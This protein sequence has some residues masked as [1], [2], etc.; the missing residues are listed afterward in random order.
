M[1]KCHNINRF[2][3]NS[4][5]SDVWG[6]N[7]HSQGKHGSHTHWAAPSLGL[8]G[9]ICIGHMLDIEN[10]LVP[11]ILINGQ[12]QSFLPQRNHWT[13][14]FMDSYYRSTPAGEY[15]T[16][17]LLALRETKCFTEDDVFVAHLTLTNDSHEPMEI[18]LS[19]A[20]PFPQIT[21]AVYQVESKISPRSIGKNLTLKGFLVADF[22]CECAKN[23]TLPAQSSIHLRYGFAFS[24]FSV[25]AAK[26]ALDTALAIPDPIS[27][28]EK[29]FNQW[30]RQNA[31]VLETEN[32]DL[33]KVYYYR[34]FVIKC[35]IHEPRIFLPD[36][37]FEGP[38]VYESPFGD[39]FGAPIG[40]SVPFQIEEMKWMKDSA[41]LR[42]HIHNWC[43]GHGAMQRYIQFTPMAIWHFY[44]QTWDSSILTDFYQQ[45]QEFTIA[46]INKNDGFLPKTAGS[47][48][49]G[50][51][52]QP[53]F[54]QHTTPSWDWRHDQEGT[55][56]G[57][58]KTV[59]YRVDACVMYTAN[60]LACKQMAE[61]LGK[62]EDAIFFGEHTDA[63]LAKMQALLWNESK[64]FFF[65]FD[66]A[67]SKQCDRAYSYDGFMPLMFSLFGTDFYPVFR[68]L[69]KTG[70]FDGGFGITSIDK[71][72]PMYW[73]DN[74]ITGPTE[75]SLSH[76][77]HYRCC[78]NGPI[79]PF[80]V[81]LVLEALGCSLEKMPE[82]TATFRRIF[83]EYTE[84][85]FAFGDRSVPCIRE[86][87]RPSDGTTFSPYTEYFHSEWINLFISYYLG[88][89]VTENGIRFHPSTEECFVLDDVVIQGKHYRFTQAYLDGKLT[90]TTSELP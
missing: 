50:A 6:S 70:R 25:D 90:Q 84:L 17:G 67:V 87:Y 21:H 40:L 43:N 86:H 47:W 63:A 72:C 77:H 27:E 62:K 46:Q 69:N 78:W 65:D 8:P 45:I 16:S 64:Q 71:E 18:S 58:E 74:C 82:L 33:L 2:L 56:L 73:F 76:P 20:V 61:K 19:L 29:R 34:F 10:I 13:P 85:H 36:S 5:R 26:K 14:A 37:D 38:C 66:P 49:T 59:L 9:N 11:Q 39:W 42:S 60:L 80:A 28:A 32:S 68:Q 53:S 83:N 1:N 44:L 55:A 89:H 75:A 79:W 54:Y 81:S 4:Q 3:E 22:F 30:M 41:V 57:F 35:G 52:Y 48:L 23:F 31:P 7:I 51:E 24:C 88:I 15:A 12:S